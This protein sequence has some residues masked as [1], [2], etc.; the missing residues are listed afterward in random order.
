VY[1]DWGSLEEQD[2]V[3]DEICDGIT[4][5]QKENQLA[6]LAALVYNLDFTYADIERKVEEMDKEIYDY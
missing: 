5:L 3:I 1:F 2:D 4:Y 6:V